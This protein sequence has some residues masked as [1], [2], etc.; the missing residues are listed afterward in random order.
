MA[1]IV[2]KGADVVKSMKGGLAGRAAEIASRFAQPAVAF[3]RVGE[4][5]DDVAYERGAVKR[6]EGLGIK[7]VPRAFDARVSGDEFLREFRAINGDPSVHA[8]L[9]FMPLP[10]GID[11]DAVKA[12]ISP[13]KDVDCIGPANNA[14]LFAGG[15]S[16]HRPCTP[17]AVMEMLKFNGIALAG[18]RVTVVGRSPVVGKP[19]AM[20]LLAEHAT[21][22][23]CHTR[24]LDLAGEC[25]RA[26][27]LIAAAG[28]ANMIGAGFIKPGAVVIDVGINVGADGAVCGDVDFEAACGVAGYITPVPGGVGA[29]T[30]TVLARNVLNA[31]EAA[32]AAEA[33]EN[34][35]LQ[36]GGI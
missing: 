34:F 2:L 32:Y 10:P 13:A 31:A 6:C 23:V 19:L 20:M 30:T 26:D 24:T 12:A 5:P 3:V 29:V 33:A 28:K 15:A 27:I 36:N 1:A 22:T 21:V 4:R 16:G 17:S 11:Q 14:A 8:I 7:C 35:S 9:A 18:R 25:R